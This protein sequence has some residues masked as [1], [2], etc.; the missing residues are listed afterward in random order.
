MAPTP[1]VSITLQLSIKLAQNRET[2]A[3]FGEGLPL[4]RVERAAIPRG[5]SSAP[6]RARA[7]CEE[8]LDLRGGVP[9]VTTGCPDRVELAGLRPARDRLGVDAEL[10]RDLGRRQKIGEVDRLLST[11]SHDTLDSL[12]AQTSL[13]ARLSMTI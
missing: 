7:S 11:S 9:A 12:C 6:T 3:N 13:P 10:L 8:L 1:I 5:E 4:L 2:P